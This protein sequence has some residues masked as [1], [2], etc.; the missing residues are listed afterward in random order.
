VTQYSCYYYTVQL[1]CSNWVIWPDDPIEWS[2]WVNWLSALTEWSSWYAFLNLWLSS[3]S[4]CSDWMLWLDTLTEC[5]DWMLGLNASTGCSD[6]MLRLDAPTGCFG[7]VCWLGALAWWSCRSP[8]QSIW[9]TVFGHNN[10][11]SLVGW[12]QGWVSNMS[13]SPTRFNPRVGQ[14]FLFDG[15]GR[16]LAI[17]RRSNPTRQI[18]RNLILDKIR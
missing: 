8:S 6:W 4:E 5:S 18:V 9:L 16:V 14:K 7:W 11:L 15:S 3:L 17:V 12:P 1:K 13:D 2:D 10:H